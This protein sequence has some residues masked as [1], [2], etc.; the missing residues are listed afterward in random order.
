ME[1]ITTAEKN[2]MALISGLILGV[3]YLVIFSAYNLM[4]GNFL[5]YG[6]AKF[7][8]Y[9]IYMVLIGV[10]AARIRKANGGYISFRDLFGAIFIM[11]LISEFFYYAFSFSYF[12]FID[13]GFTDKIKVGYA[14]MMEKFKLPDDKLDDAISKFNKSIDESKNITISSYIL[15]YFELVL[16]DSLVGLLVC[17]IVRKEKPL[18]G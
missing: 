18:F 6:I 16:M 9:A 1:N 14:G 17:L 12:K 3:I 10:M 4:V 8:G 2:K 15:N 7:A 5:V 11:I 13:P